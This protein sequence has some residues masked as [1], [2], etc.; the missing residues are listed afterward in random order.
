MDG[1]R[2][3]SLTRALG[4]GRSRRSVVKGLGKGIGAAALGAVGLSRLGKAEA[5]GGGNSACAH[6]CTAA[7]PPGPA[8]GQ[9]V[10]DA[11]HGTGACVACGADIT[12]F[13][14]GVC[15]NPAT[16]VNNC[17][18]CGNVCSAPANATATCASGTCGF[19]CASGFTLCNGAC[20]NEQTDTNNCGS[21]GNVCPTGASC[22]N[23]VCACP[24]SQTACGGACV[25]TTSDSNNCGAC[26]TACGGGDVCTAGQCFQ[27]FPNCPG[28]FAYTKE[29]QNLC[30]PSCN[31]PCGVPC[32]SSDQCLSG[33]FCALLPFC[34]S[35][36][37]CTHG[38]SS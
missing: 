27:S 1:D 38:V 2:F 5:A 6:F 30:E 23:D 16:D 28:C 29:G 11:A 17:G 9:C 34:G 35:G 31:P 10:S 14:N 24:S 12:H 37:F 4:S 36:Y 7:F 25:D 19:T 26:G 21:C 20:V 18:A 15:V 8:R 13:C 3:D 32:T 33:D 22:A